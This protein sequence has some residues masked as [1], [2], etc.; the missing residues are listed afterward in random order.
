MRQSA[1]L[2][3]GWA[4]VVA[5]FAH[6]TA[7]FNGFVVAQEP[8]SPA[9]RSALGKIFTEDHV[10]NS[11][12]SVCERAEQLPDVARFKFLAAYV[13]PSE[14]HDTLRLAFD[15]TP[16]CPAPVV[17]PVTGSLRSHSG[18]DT[19]A[20]VGVPRFSG[21]EFVSPAFEL[22]RVAAKL[23][24]LPEVR[25]RVEKWQPTKAEDRKCVAAMLCAI[26]C[27]QRS[28]KDAETQLQSLIQLARE[29]PGDR[30]ELTPEA[31][32]LWTAAEHPEMKA[33]VEEFWAIL[34]EDM[35]QDQHHRHA[36]SERWMRLVHAKRPAWPLPPNSL[37]LAETP[38]PMWIPVSRMIAE[39]RGAGYPQPQWQTQLGKVFHAVC[40]DQ[41]SLY[42]RSPLSGKFTVEADATAFAFRDIHLGYGSYW[43]GPYWDLKFMVQ[44]DFRGDQKSIPI[45]P[46]LTRMFDTMRV[47]MDVSDEKAL[48]YIN[49]RLAD[50]QQLQAP[51]DPWLSIHSWWYTNGTV[52]NLRITGKPVIL[53]TVSLLTPGLNGW[54][55]Y[56]DESGGGQNANWFSRQGMKSTLHAGRFGTT[57]P[58]ESGDR[59]LY[60][61]RREDL[62]QTD[63]ESLLRYHRP[64]IEDGTIEYE[65]FYEPGKSHVH[66]VLD[67]MCLILNPEGIDIHWATDGRHDRT[68]VG[69]DNIVSEPQHR[70]S[71]GPLPLKPAEW[72]RV[73]LTT[74]GDT[75]NLS[76]NGELIYS[77]PLEAT[78][79]RT[80]G[81]FHWA[82]Q[83]EIRVRKMQWLGGWPKQLPPLSEQSLADLSLD[84]SLGDRMALK[85][86]LA[87]D[88]RNGVPAHLL[89]IAG[90][91]WKTHLKQQ[92]D[93]IQITRPGGNYA[94]HI[95]NSPI[96][97][98]GDFDII[99]EYDQLQIQAEPG[100]EGYIELIADLDDERSSEH[101]IYRK[102]YV[103]PDRQE[104]V[105][106]AA[107]FEKRGGETQYS[108]FDAPP[109]E[110]VSGRLRLVRRGKTLYSLIA[111]RDSTHYRLIHRESVTQDESRFRFIVGH[112]KEGV[113]SVLLKS[114]DVRA[115]GSF[116]ATDGP[117]KTIEELDAERAKLLA[118]RTWDF[119]AKKPN[120]ASQAKREFDVFAGGTGL[121]YSEPEGLRVNAPGS[122]NWSATGLLSR[123]RIE[124]DFDIAL[125]L[126]VLQLEPC[127]Q[128]HESCVY[129]LT[130]FRDKRQ[131]TVETK[132]A[133]HSEGDKK[134]ETQLRRVR[135]DKTFDYRELVS[136]P[137]D[138]AKLMRMARRGDVIY[139]IFQSTTQKTPVVL[140][141][142]QIG[143]DPVIPGDLKL[144]IHTGGD[145]RMTSVRFRTLT[146]WAEKVIE[147]QQ[148]PGKPNP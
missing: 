104:Q 55:A 8:R 41:D 3:A 84:T 114:L 48:L 148:P 15:M 12:Y 124:G 80:F 125:E 117:L 142:L 128:Y 9:V 138:D 127:M 44:G 40:H 7:L 6:V 77:R 140:G 65:F 143:R 63:S 79:L 46:P 21:G 87:H 16:T 38:R 132:F 49:G 75:V 25:Q 10:A 94:L 32:G 82:D 110:S 67:R 130:E 85:S 111:E 66:P 56:Y 4:V 17:K 45:R 96:S 20:A 136:Q 30:L 90:A 101:H 129:L 100:G 23:G 59:E 19:K 52:S 118:H 27:A 71:K 147:P 54:V 112:H 68:G 119:Q 93:G 106:Q 121:F 60:S 14:D 61:R 120:E 1:K 26:S 141:A 108:F 134:A 78:N 5:V 73:A 92:G 57:N 146:V 29:Q 11:A 70:T 72:N 95:V 51:G 135:R 50:T 113:T 131:T 105:T 97:L 99:A 35:R 98:T 88:F 37:T 144:M 103:F 115:Q 81:L 86:V 123:A 53:E 34:Y 43:V 42:Y 89:S 31:F 74:V 47:R 109:E 36:R 58:P 76:L 18:H 102:Q 22:I 64:L 2:V 107:V 83:T 69:P 126:D 24:R 33:L 62:S 133:I 139:Q 39:T 13:L 91:D 145:K 28:F 116:G 122:D 137:S